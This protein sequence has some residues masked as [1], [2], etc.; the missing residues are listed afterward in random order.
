MREVERYP[1]CKGET[2]GAEEANAWYAPR[3]D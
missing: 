1:V 2:R 3:D